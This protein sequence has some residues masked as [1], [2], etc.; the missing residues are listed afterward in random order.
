MKWQQWHIKVGPPETSSLAHLFLRP[1][2]HPFLSCSPPWR[3]DRK[4]DQPSR[5]HFSRVLLALSAGWN[6]RDPLKLENGYRTEPAR[7][8]LSRA[9]EECTRELE[10][11]RHAAA[12]IS[13]FGVKTCCEPPFFPPLKSLL[14]PEKGELNTPIPWRPPFCDTKRIQSRYFLSLRCHNFCF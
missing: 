7:L 5:R 2:P 8:D 14:R 6:K 4:R 11:S 9:L 13:F 3:A 12:V 1:R 10:R